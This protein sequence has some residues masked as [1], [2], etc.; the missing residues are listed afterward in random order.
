M[1]SM[2]PGGSHGPSATK[3]L[4]QGKNPILIFTQYEYRNKLVNDNSVGQGWTV[5]S[6]AILGSCVTSHPLDNRIMQF[7]VVHFQR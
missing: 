2:L 7:D 6:A 1:K 4:P 3:S 5:S